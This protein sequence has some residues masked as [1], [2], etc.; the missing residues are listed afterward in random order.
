MLAAF[1]RTA[2]SDRTGGD[3]SLVVANAQAVRDNGQWICEV[4]GDQT[5]PTLTSPAAT[6]NV[7]SFH[8]TPQYIGSTI[9][10]GNQCSCGG[11]L[12][13]QLDVIN[14]W[15][16][17]F[18]MWV[19]SYHSFI[20]F[21]RILASVQLTLVLMPILA[22]MIITMAWHLRVHHYIPLYI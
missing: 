7:Q 17:R 10:T 4:T 18:Q 13:D 19:F 14:R 12:M 8:F 20:T 5:Q 15:A 16:T 21:M 3:C 11:K 9:S 6:V 2:Q 1:Q 22:P